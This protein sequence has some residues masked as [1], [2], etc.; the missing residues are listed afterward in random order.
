VW[1][2]GQV[3]GQLLVTRWNGAAWQHIPSPTGVTSKT[4][5]LGSETIVGTSPS[6]AWLFVSSHKAGSSNGTTVAEHWTGSTW[7]KAARF[8]GSLAVSAAVAP[9]ATSVW[10]FGAPYSGG[11]A[12]AERYNGSTWTRV[13]FPAAAPLQV[14]A[15][16]AGDIWAISRTTSTPKSRIPAAIEHW[17]GSQWKPAGLPRIPLSSK[18]AQH[19]EACGRAE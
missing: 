13:S 2:A 19:V 1:G 6:S 16:S 17:N 7:A 10:A 3:N 8:P 5:I 12:Y 14:S 18:P 11:A 9:S 4:E 15:V